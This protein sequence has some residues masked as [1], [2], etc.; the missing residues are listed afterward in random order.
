M[1]LD[2]TRARRLIVAFA[3]FGLLLR[4]AFSLGYWVDRPL[5]HDEHE[6]LGLAR[7][8]AEGKGFS[9]RASI[10]AETPQ[11]F[12]RAPGYPFFLSLLD[13]GGSIPTSTPVRVKV[14]QSVIGAATIGII[15][16]LAWAA[17]GPRSGVVAAGIAA[18]Y[19]SLVWLPAYVLSEALYA[20]LALGTAFVL[21]RGVDEKRIAL[22]AS[23]G[24]LTGA[25]ALVRP[26]MLFFLP[27]AV[28]WILM[29]R[30]PTLAVA[31]AVGAAV[32]IVPW[33]IRNVRVHHRLVLI[34][35][36]GGV[37]FWTGNHP[38]AIG[39]GDLAAN[40]ELKRADLAFRRG[41]PGLSPEEL[42]P[43]YYRD[44]FAWIA[45]HPGDWTILLARKAFFTVV[46]VGPSYALHSARYRI[47]SIAPYVIVLP[48]AVAG[49]WRLFRSPRRPVALFLLAASAILTCIVFFPQERFRIPV[50]DPVLIICASALAGRSRS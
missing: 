7:S 39:E 46:P 31:L 47:A 33:T 19:P 4:L 20:L 24:V 25:A 37:T 36:E 30:R 18:I 12:G 8:L 49:A 29:R 42:E 32:V 35:S 16:L 50:I 13:S 23:A 40:P 14:A 1:S 26:A 9:F 2:H 43:L 27:L 5:T 44:A 17:A 15:G 3:A 6:Y 38:L 22:V 41:F 45:D 34:A 11:L 28:V 48:F 10:E 21:Q